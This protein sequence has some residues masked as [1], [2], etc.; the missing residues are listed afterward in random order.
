[1]SSPSKNSPDVPSQELE[2][3]RLQIDQVD[4]QLVQLMEQRASL[5]FSIGDLKREHNLALHDSVRETKIIDKVRNLT[6]PSGPLSASE[7]EALFRALIDCFRSFEGIHM[8]KELGASQLTKAH[9]DF[10]KPQVVVLWGFGL[11][12]SSFYLALNSTLPHWNFLVV[13]PGI[14]VDSFLAWKQKNHF[15]NIDLI[16]SQQMQQGNIF[17]LGASVEVN[18]QHLSEFNFPK[19]ALVFDLGST[20]KEMNRIFEQR[21]IQGNSSFTFVGGH[22]L[23]GKE[24][25]GFENGNALLFYNKVFCWVSPPSQPLSPE[26]MTTC[27]ILSQFLGAKPFW[28]TGDEHDAALAWTSHLMQLVSSTLATCLSKKSFSHSKEFFPAVIHDLLR[29]S[30]SSFAMWK[31]VMTSNQKEIQM[32]TT[33]LIQHLEQ[34]RQDLE[35]P[36]GCEELFHQSNHF[37]N[38]FKKNEK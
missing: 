5:V 37:Y 34:V 32:A 13:D 8:Q 30:G 10:Q 18:A 22:P 16:H 20:K 12:G 7:M 29:I 25:S 2:T 31:S 21:Q 23:A 9:L 36:N 11:L 15:S 26:I 35:N 24:S 17:V 28:T 3:L 1:M 6:S 14:N 38:N 27:E 4:R 33:E 19:Q